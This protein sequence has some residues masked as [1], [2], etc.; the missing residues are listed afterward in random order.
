M[1]EQ[2]KGE[3]SRYLH[4]LKEVCFHSHSHGGGHVPPLVGQV[5]AARGSA[6]Q[7]RALI[8]ASHS[9]RLA[10]KSAPAVMR[11]V[12]AWEG[13]P[14]GLG[15]VRHQISLLNTKPRRAEQA[16]QERCPWQGQ[17]A[18]PCLHQHWCHGCLSPSPS[19]PLLSS[20]GQHRSCSSPC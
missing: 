14:Q 4:L 17:G 10:L 5:S 11:A 18:P 7:I 3:P 12:L 6:W 15:A 9:I 19:H 16:A 1:V 13:E 2:R 20:P 8:L